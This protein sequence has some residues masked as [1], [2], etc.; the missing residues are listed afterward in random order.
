[1][2][3]SAE[4]RY[5]RTIQLTPQLYSFYV[6]HV[7]IIN[8]F[9]KCW[10][11][12]KL[13]VTPLPYLF[14]CWRNEVSFQDQKPWENGEAHIALQ[15]CDSANSP[16]FSLST[17][18]KHLTRAPRSQIHALS[19][20]IVILIASPPRAIIML[21]Y[22]ISGDSEQQ[23]LAVTSAFKVTLI[24]SLQSP[25]KAFTSVFYK[26]CQCGAA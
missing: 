20:A 10:K 18:H 14:L 5:R 15:A 1:M 8:V 17:C 3:Q 11:A 2:S 16:F 4:A 6:L 7:I 22:F 13:G 24:L 19:S 21:H 9:K 26:L 23:D 25:V 12:N